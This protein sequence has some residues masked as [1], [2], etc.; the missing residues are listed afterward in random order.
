MFP[1]R[2][3]QSKAFPPAP[4]PPLQKVGGCP[5][6]ALANYVSRCCPKKA[7]TFSRD[8]CRQSQGSLT[9][10]HRG[11]FYTEK[12][13]A[14][15]LLGLDAKHVVPLFSSPTFG[16]VLSFTLLL[17]SRVLLLPLL[18]CT[19]PDVPSCVAHILVIFAANF[20]PSRSFKLQ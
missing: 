2:V 4:L 15:P 19:S 11:C 1:P 6:V 5:Q 16:S 9:V 14:I 17:A 12:I 20:G 18:L 13:R 7:S 3:A 10:A 8:V